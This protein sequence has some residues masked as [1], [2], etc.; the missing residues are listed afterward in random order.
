MTEE[1][2]N[3]QDHVQI[4]GLMAMVGANVPRP[5]KFSA[6]KSRWGLF[7]MKLISRVRAR[8]VQ[9]TRWVILSTVR[10][11][12]VGRGRSRFRQLAG[13]NNPNTSFSCLTEKVGSI[14]YPGPA[15]AIEFRSS[16]VAKHRLGS[17]TPKPDVE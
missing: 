15:W 11:K 17:V 14:E 13:V 4:S 5:R 6:P 12:M 16:A 3:Y 7:W 10:R 9:F 8:L 2:Q 1:E